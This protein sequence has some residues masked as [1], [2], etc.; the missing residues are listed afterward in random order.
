[1]TIHASKGLEAPVVFLADCD[2]GG[3]AKD[4]F[5]TLVHWP[6]NAKKPEHVQLVMGKDQTDNI[7]QSVQQ[8]KAA[9]QAREQLNLLYVALTRARE[10]LLIS[11]V[12]SKRSSSGWYQLIHEAMTSMATEETDGSLSYTFG[13]PEIAPSAEKE[14]AHKEKRVAIKPELK[15]PIKNLPATETMI[16]PSRANQNND[17][18]DAVLDTEHG[19]T[20][21]IIIHRALDLLSRK[22]ALSQQEV[23]QQ[24][25]SETG[26]NADDSDLKNWLQEAVETTKAVQFEEIFTLPESSQGCNELPL[27]YEADDHPVYGLIDRLVIGEKEILLVDYKTHLHVTRETAKTCAESF[28]EQMRLYREGVQRIWPDHTVRS[29][30]LFTACAELVWFN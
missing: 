24:L 12:A 6:A 4:A 3:S 17:V 8:Q 20:R 2:S 23:H 14:V 27:L 25:V 15:L 9:A 10:Y 7:T 13:Q 22:N 16:A 1:M 21:G 28:K 19:Q 30:L 26:L 11:G 18:S 29:G 5:T